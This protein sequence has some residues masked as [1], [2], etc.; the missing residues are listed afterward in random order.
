MIETKALTASA[1]GIRGGNGRRSLNYALMLVLVAASCASADLITDV[2]TSVAANEF[3]RAEGYVRH[4]RAANG[5]TPD[6]VVAMSWMARGALSAKAYS[7][8]EAYARETYQLAVGLLKNRPLDQEPNLPIGLGATIE[9]Q[10]QVLA[11]RSQRTEAVTYLRRQL[12]IYG[13]TTIAVRIQKNINLLSLE[14][15]QAPR[16]EGASLPAGRP[17]LLFFWAHWCGDCRDEAAV[18]ARIKAEFGPKGLVMIGPTQKYGYVARGEEAPP[19]VELRYIETVRR[20][21][22]GAVVPSPPIVSE[23]NFREYGVSTTPTL[24]LIGR[25][26]TVRMYHPGGISYDELRARIE[27]LR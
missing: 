25:N 11:A 5:V 13:S 2:R 23:K 22:Y 9:V 7:K 3:P 18:L 21:Y 26:G 24:V 19:A 4:Y 27:A 1:V 17:V 16:L 8:A 10:A 15:R 14:G 6:L 12:A 20:E